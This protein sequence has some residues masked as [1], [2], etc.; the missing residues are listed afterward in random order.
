MKCTRVQHTCLSV[1]HAN[2]MNKGTIDYLVT[3]LLYMCDFY[4]QSC[5][6]TQMAYIH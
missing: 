5:A 4:S 3:P 1:Q 2:S 6:H